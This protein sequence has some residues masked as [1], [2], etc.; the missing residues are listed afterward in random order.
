MDDDDDN[1][2]DVFSRFALD[3]ALERSRRRIEEE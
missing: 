2:D 1:T 3:A